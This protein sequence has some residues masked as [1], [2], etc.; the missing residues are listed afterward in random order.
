MNLVN[1]LLEKAETKLE[2][3]V[4]MR[5]L[6]NDY[7]SNQNPSIDI[8]A[9]SYLTERFPGESIN[10]MAER[11]EYLDF[12]YALTGREEVFKNGLKEV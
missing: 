6:A 1:D 10:V 9:K 3:I 4:A 11:K 12:Y 5:N 7:M 2:V 8:L